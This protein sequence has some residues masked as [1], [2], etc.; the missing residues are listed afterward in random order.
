MATR[1]LAAGCFVGL[2]IVLAA[3]GWRA[4]ST[5]SLAFLRPERR[6]LGD[7]D[8]MCMSDKHVVLMGDSTMA[9]AAEGLHH[10]FGC[11]VIRQASRCDFASYYGIAVAHEQ[12]NSAIPPGVGPAL[13]GRQN[14]GC[15]DCSGCHSR[16][17]YCPIRNVTLEFVGM[18]FAKDVEY[19]TW[20][21]RFTQESVIKGYLGGTTAPPV[22][23][24]LQHWPTRLGI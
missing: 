13:T 17:W 18:E 10:L 5:G 1:T 7:N 22:R 16:H 8:P 14:R 21:G 12:L 9:R 3:C 15:M 6:W 11:K 24:G 23:S 19:P 20:H 4:V 2:F